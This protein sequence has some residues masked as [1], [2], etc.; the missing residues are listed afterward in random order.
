MRKIEN[1]QREREKGEKE[2]V[3]P[4]RRRKRKKRERGL[5]GRVDSDMSEEIE[6]IKKI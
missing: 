4:E 3:H 6:F 1:R 2:R 5:L